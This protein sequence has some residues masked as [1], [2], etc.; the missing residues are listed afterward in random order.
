MNKLQKK[1]Y[2]TVSFF[3]KS[4]K[5]LMLNI[6]DKIPLFIKKIFPTLSIYFCVN[7]VVYLRNEN[8]KKIYVLNNWYNNVFILFFNLFL[9]F[10]FSALLFPTAILAFPFLIIAFLPILLSFLTLPFVKYVKKDSTKM[11]FWWPFIIVKYLD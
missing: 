11:S 3:S 1:L 2:L 6:L 5:A 10:V 7:R 9:D 4:D 8:K